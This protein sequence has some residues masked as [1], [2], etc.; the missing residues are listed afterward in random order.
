MNNRGMHEPTANVPLMRTG[1]KTYVDREWSRWHIP[2]MVLVAFA[3][4]LAI[5][6]WLQTYKLQTYNELIV[7]FLN[8][9]LAPPHFHFSFGYETGAIAGSIA[10]GNGFS[11]PFEGSTG[12]TAWIGPIYPYMCAAVFKVFGLYTELSAAV[13]LSINCVLAALTCP[14]IVRIGRKIFDPATGLAAGWVWAAGVFF[15]RWPTT[16]VW[17]LS[18]TALLLAIAIDCTL[19]LPENGSY[20]SWGKFGILWGLIALTNPSLLTVLGVSGL[21]LAYNCRR[22]RAEFVRRAA[23]SALLCC[24]V[25]APWLVRNRLVF[26]RWVFLRSNAGFEF[27]LGNYAGSNGLGWFGL[28]PSQNKREFLKYQQ[29]GELEYVASKQHQAL[30]WV[31]NNPV[32]FVK[33]SGKRVY[34]FWAGTQLDYIAPT[35]EVWR[36]WMFWPLSLLTAL[37]LWLAIREHRP[38]GLFLGILILLFPFA[39]YITFAQ[40]R[41]RHYVEPLMLLP[42]MYFL[43]WPARAWVVSTV[44]GPNSKMSVPLQTTFGTTDERNTGEADPMF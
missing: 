36:K 23:V 29:M 18:L 1:T 33:L 22:D 8:Q 9:K 28:H 4:R 41:Y 25:I 43:L 3:L 7:D 39:Y 15:A 38:G 19:S 13:M 30:S 35:F 12:P 32:D 40:P 10:S 20:V 34:D 6:F 2:A 24:V 17:D 37:G 27:S 31:K 5:V 26:N 44:Q 11:S 14:F 16:W 42:A 21:Y